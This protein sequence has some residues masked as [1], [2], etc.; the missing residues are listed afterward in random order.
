MMHEHLNR[1]LFRAISSG[2][3]NP[4]DLAAIAL[5]HL[6]ELCP[7]CRREFESWRRELEDRAV[8]SDAADYEAV[9]ERARIRVERLP[10]GSE[11]P[12]EAEI[13]EAR[14]RADELLR[15]VPDQRAEWLRFEAGR[16]SALLLAEV[17]IEESRRRTPAYPRD[18]Y[19][20]ASLARLVLHHAPSSLR[21]T[22]LYARA[23]AYMAN[24]VRVIGDLPRA[25][26]IMEDAR[27][28]LR[29]QGGGDR[30]VRA[31]L[32]GLEGSLRNDQERSEEA[33]PL[34][35]RALMT[36]RLEQMAGRTA[37]ILIKLAG[38]HIRLN[39]PRRSLSL[40]IEAEKVL[41]SE[42]D[43]RLRLLILHNRA[44]GLYY[45]GY[46]QQ[47]QALLDESS[48]LAGSQDQPLNVL[49][50]SWISGKAARKLA[51]LDLAEERLVSVREGFSC[52]GL[53]SDAA[54]ASMDLCGL[55]L[56]QGRR[57]EAEEL[58]DAAL[59]V[60]EELE[61][62]AKASAARA[63]RARAASA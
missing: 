23:L 44:L 15:L 14:S 48:E 21:A 13:R 60:F 24:A 32:D 53:R 19:T 51:D 54:E 34:L 55:Y 22:A 38:A 6:F 4:G 62:P 39:E 50:R 43:P 26:Q 61:L 40:L 12:V 18:G 58:A 11:A 9:I 3:R 59:P 8:P 45:S 49:R 1:E 35:L 31:E 56:E 42:P 46:P 30:L 36:S 41:D 27:F 52:R 47:A 17:L 29:C 10:G 2:W 37:A 5:A 63:L 20:L 28:L 57:K 33:V 16:F 7:S 25:D